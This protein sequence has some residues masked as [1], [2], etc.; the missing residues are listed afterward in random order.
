[1]DPPP[2][3]DV[4]GKIW[5][6][7][8]PRTV[9]KADE[10]LRYATQTAM[11]VR[12]SATSIA[13]ER[14]QESGT[15]AHHGSHPFSDQFL[16][17][18][19][20]PKPPVE[21]RV[22]DIFD[23]AISREGDENEEDGGERGR[24]GRRA[25]SRRTENLPF[26]SSPSPQTP[27]LQ[28]TASASV[29]EHSLGGAAANLIAEAAASNAPSTPFTG[30]QLVWSH[31]Y[32][33]SLP[34]PQVIETGKRKIQTASPL[35]ADEIVA[36]VVEKQR[37]LYVHAQWH[38]DDGGYAEGGTGQE[39]AAK[40]W[41][42]WSDDEVRAACGGHVN[43]LLD[44]LRLVASDTTI[45][46]T[47]QPTSDVIAGVSG[48]AVAAAAEA[49]TSPSSISASADRRSI[50]IGTDGQHWELRVRTIRHSNVASPSAA[51]AAAAE[52]FVESDLFLV[53]SHSDVQRWQASID[54]ARN[55]VPRDFATS[56][57]GNGTHNGGGRT[58]SVSGNNGVGAE[59][60]VKPLR[61]ASSQN[62]SWE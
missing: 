49:S 51:A 41:D 42:V 33:C 54:E 40:L 3:A 46:S 10:R 48:L 9:S 7:A 43:A 38:G 12:H 57:W 19:S 23:E 37:Q 47:Q 28:A 29:P 45:P 52:D 34:A 24:S 18:R 53:Y 4:G 39:A 31:R 59:F 55:W 60:G 11:F 44:A 16:Q 1:M 14:Q 5:K 22:H 62:P 35:S 30:H 27:I 58:G 56:R 25:R 50:T 13:A 15:S 21:T 32:E 6:A 36:R 26:L 17:Q 2:P 61:N 8:R 20:V